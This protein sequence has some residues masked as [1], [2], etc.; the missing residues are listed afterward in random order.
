VF[1]IDRVILKGIPVG[2]DGARFDATVLENIVKQLVKDKLSDPDAKMEDPASRVAGSK[3][4]RT[5]VVSTRGLNADGPSALFRSYRST[6]AL[7]S[8]CTIWEAA[9]ATSAAPTYFRPIRIGGDLLGSWFVDGG[10]TNNNPS[11]VGC[12]EARDIWPKVKR[13]CV[14]SVGTG[15]LPN[16][17]VVDKNLE[18]VTPTSEPSSWKLPGFAKTVTSIVTNTPSGAVEVKRILEACLKLS[19][20][21]EVAHQRMFQTFSSST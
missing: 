8:T 7:A 11:E 17:E 2:S 6:Q 1:D 3:Y 5:F 10:L 20:N 12:D 9:R 19:T 21:A 4:C 16:V 13:F 15:R 18:P 14:V